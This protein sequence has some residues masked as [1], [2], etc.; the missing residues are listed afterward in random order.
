MTAKGPEVTAAVTNESPPP[1]HLSLRVSLYSPGQPLTSCPP[2]SASHV[3][4]L[5]PELGSVVFL[6]YWQLPLASLNMN[7]IWPLRCWLTEEFPR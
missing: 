5:P 3:L 4:L 2:A 1:C 7:F 6:E